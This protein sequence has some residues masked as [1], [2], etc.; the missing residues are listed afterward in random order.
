MRFIS[1]KMIESL[2]IPLLP[3]GEIKVQERQF[4][5]Q[6]ALV[7]EIENLKKKIQALSLVTLPENWA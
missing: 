3:E 2:P 1:A 5:E 7:T 6:Q 4:Q